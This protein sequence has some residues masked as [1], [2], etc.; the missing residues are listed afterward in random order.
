MKNKKLFTTLAALTVG[1]VVSTGVILA[2]ALTL[3]NEHEKHEGDGK[4]DSKC[5]GE[6]GCSGEHKEEHKDEHKK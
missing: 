5:S 1:S 6:N 4:G 3:A 2:P